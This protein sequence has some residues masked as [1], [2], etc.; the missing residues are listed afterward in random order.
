LV[1]L[2]AI[3]VLEL[4]PC[5]RETHTVAIAGQVAVLRPCGNLFRRPVGSAG[6]IC[7]SPVPLLQ[8]VLVLAFELVV[9]D[10]AP[11]VAALVANLR[12]GVAARA[13]DLGVVGQLARLLETGIE[14]LTQLASLFTPIRFEQVSASIREHDDVLVP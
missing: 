6:A 2:L 13:I 8:E 5:V 1:L 14:R 3:T 7:P 10:D 4:D 9:E 11:D 12:L